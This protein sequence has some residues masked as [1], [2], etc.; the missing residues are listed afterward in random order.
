MVY[1]MSNFMMVHS[2]K[3]LTCANATLNKPAIMLR[4]SRIGM[5]II[6][7]DGHKN[8]FISS[9]YQLSKRLVKY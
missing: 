7:V 5:D 8:P 2:M 6:F 3:A 9:K 1:I 4:L